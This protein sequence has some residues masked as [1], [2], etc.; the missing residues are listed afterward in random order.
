MAGQAAD[1][2]GE[3][4]KDSCFA[5]FHPANGPEQTTFSLGFCEGGEGDL[6]VLSLTAAAAKKETEEQARGRRSKPSYLT[7]LISRA[8]SA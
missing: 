5:C 1:A 7:E 8:H 4:R 2:G 3:L 6:L